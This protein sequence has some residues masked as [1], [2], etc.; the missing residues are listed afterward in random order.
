[1]NAC[2]MGVCMNGREERKEREGV[3]SVKK[4]ALVCLCVCVTYSFFFFLL[5]R[6]FYFFSEA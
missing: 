3:K 4:G 6:R 5:C 2:A 1:M